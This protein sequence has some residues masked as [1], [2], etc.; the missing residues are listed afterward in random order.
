MKQKITLLCLCFEGSVKFANDAVKGSSLLFVVELEPNGSV[1]LLE[2][3]SFSEC[4]LLSWVPLGRPSNKSV[5]EKKSE[6]WKG[7]LLELV[8]LDLNG[9]PEKKSSGF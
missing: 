7:S 2:K 3:A 8:D 1:F 4:L 5:P 9:S 6:L